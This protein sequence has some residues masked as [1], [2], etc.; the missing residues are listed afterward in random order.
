M[1]C[2]ILL[3]RTAGPSRLA[4]F[5]GLCL[6]LF[7]ISRFS[8]HLRA[9]DLPVRSSTSY[10]SICFYYVFVTCKVKS[11]KHLHHS[12]RFGIFW[13]LFSAIDRSKKSGIRLKTL[14]DRMHP[15]R[16]QPRV[17]CVRDRRDGGFEVSRKFSASHRKLPGEKGVPPF[18]PIRFGMH[19]A[20]MCQTNEKKGSDRLN[21]SPCVFFESYYLISS[22]FSVAV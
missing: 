5:L 1:W 6:L 20:H 19:L 8:F 12:D 14:H 21:H 17:I 4:A 10:N 9:I 13:M 16:H 18:V 11:D 22:N 3:F 2:S 15:T 7:L